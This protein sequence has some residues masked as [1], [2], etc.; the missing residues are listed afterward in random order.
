MPLCV[1]WHL[2]IRIFPSGITRERHLKPP[3]LDLIGW[4][5]APV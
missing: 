3:S 2:D 5:L 4:A 1:G